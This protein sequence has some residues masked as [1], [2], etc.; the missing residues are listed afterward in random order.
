MS[1]GLLS[2]VRKSHLVATALAIL[3]VGWILS[4][5]FAGSPGSA[6]STAAISAPKK[7]TVVPRVRVNRQT[8]QW[9]AERIVLRG[10][11]EASRVV[12]LKAETAGR[13]ETVPARE[14]RPVA[15]GEIVAT[16]AREEREARLAEARA[17]VRQRDVEYRAAAKLAEKGFRAETK[18]AEARAL[19]DSARAALEVIETDI[20]HTEIRAPFD[21]ILEQRYVE[22]GDFVD[23]G[24]DVAQVIDLD[25]L[26][27]VAQVA[28]QTIPRLTVGGEA[29][30]RLISGAS[31]RGTVSYIASSASSETRTFRVEV[32]IPNPDGRLPANMTAEIGMV[33]DRVRA[34][35]VSP[36]VLTLDDRGEVGI[37]YVDAEG[38]VAFHPVSIATDTGGEIW[39]SGLPETIDIIIVGQEF[40]KVGQKVEPVYANGVP[41]S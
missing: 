25:P 21:G 32:E 3:A 30:A 9:H 41:T 34:H 1:A 40:V 2:R 35:S 26:L 19:L 31:A 12:N 7:E 29:E 6:D 14:G 11:T 5:Q 36:A 39:I 15:K 4:G 23:L 24:K 8:A 38:I 28:E 27:V 16:F 13:V 10:Q 22:E 20:A 18:L 33:L 17:L 37:K